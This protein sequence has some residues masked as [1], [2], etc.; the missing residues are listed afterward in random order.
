MGGT[1][2]R[3]RYELKDKGQ[4]VDSGPDRRPLIEK[5]GG[6]PG[7]E[8]WETWRDGTTFCIHREAR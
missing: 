2:S 3:I 6:I 4:V 7:S 8:V 5:A 1:V